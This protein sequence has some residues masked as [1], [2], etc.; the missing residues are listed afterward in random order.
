MLG[1]RCEFGFRTGEPER[2]G[3]QPEFVGGQPSQAFAVEAEPG[4]ARG[5]KHLDGV[6]F[7][8][9]DQHVGGDLRRVGHHV[10]R[11]LRIDPRIDHA[12]VGALVDGVGDGTQ[13]LEC[14]GQVAA[15]AAGAEQH[16]H[17]SVIGRFSH[18][19]LACQRSQSS[20]MST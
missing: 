10:R 13:P 17:G 20:R 6:V 2:H 8:G 1:D 11:F 16:D 14:Q 19:G 5:R 15:C 9:G 4:T 12:D 3:R 18:R 7:G